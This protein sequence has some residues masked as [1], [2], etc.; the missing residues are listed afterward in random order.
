MAATIKENMRLVKVLKLQNIFKPCV[1]LQGKSNENHSYIYNFPLFSP[2]NS[3]EP[4]EENT[5]FRHQ[6]MELTHF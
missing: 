1:F 4:E 3:K 2:V 5:D 6:E